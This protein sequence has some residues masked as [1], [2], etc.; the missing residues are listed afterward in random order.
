MSQAYTLLSF[1]VEEFDMPLEYNHP[2]SA[3]EQ[4]EVGK[5]GLDA[6]IPLWEKYALN[7][8]L[9]T[10]ANFALNFPDTIKAL[11]A[12]HEIASHTFYHSDFKNEHLLESKMALEK[13]AGTKVNGLRMPRM[14][15]V[16]MTEVINAGYVY[17]SSINPTYLPGRYNNF[18][19]PRTVY[20]DDKMIR[21]PASVSPIVR[22]PLFWLGFKN[23]PYWLFL[24]ICKQ[25]LKKDGYICLYFHPWEFTDISA[26]KMPSYTKKPNGNLLLQRLERLINDLAKYSEFTTMQDYLS[27]KKFINKK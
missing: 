25:T 1:D 5:K 8:T 11:A 4:M 13:I 16:E 27:L 26:Y 19:L 20:T 2:I 23:Y 22:L 18:H 15:K 14:R 6:L 24:K 12:N 9:F 10:T 21:M 7:T 3:Q 17:D